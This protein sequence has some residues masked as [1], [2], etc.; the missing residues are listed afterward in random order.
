M[1]D[2][3]FDGVVIGAG[4]GRLNAAAYIRKRRTDFRAWHCHRRG[5][6]HEFRRGRYSF[7]VAGI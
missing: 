6:S 2:E 4:L 5:Y 7:E 1:T 3:K